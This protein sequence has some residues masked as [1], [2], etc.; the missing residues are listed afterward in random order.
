MVIINWK[1]LCCSTMRMCWCCRGG[2]VLLSRHALGECR[3]AG[4]EQGLTGSQGWGCLTHGWD[5]CGIAVRLLTGWLSQPSSQ[6]CALSIYTKWTEKLVN[7]LWSI[8]VSSKPQRDKF[9]IKLSGTKMKQTRQSLQRGENTSKIQ[10]ILLSFVCLLLNF[11]SPFSV[12]DGLANPTLFVTH[13]SL[14][15]V[16]RRSSSMENGDL[17]QESC[18]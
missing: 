8:F 5:Q 11:C 4:E 10:T 13:A 18:V 2:D 12:Q 3:W 9:F 14:N 15:R 17:E 1:D 7:T 16:L 6:P